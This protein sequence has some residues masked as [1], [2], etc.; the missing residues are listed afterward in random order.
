MLRRKLVQKNA[1]SLIVPCSESRSGCL[2][3]TAALAT[4]NRR[5]ILL[6]FESQYSAACGTTRTSTA[7]WSSGPAGNQAWTIG[8]HML[9]ILSRSTM[10]SAVPL[11]DT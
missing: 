7:C 10:R 3:V 5:T 9:R 8:F 6:S 11:T 4:A 2:P 1:Y